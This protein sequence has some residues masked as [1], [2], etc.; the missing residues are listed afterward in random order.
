MLRTYNIPLTVSL[1]TL[2]FATSGCS[3]TTPGSTDTGA[4]GLSGEIKLNLGESTGDFEIEAGTSRRLRGSGQIDAQ[5]Q[6]ITS[7]TIRID[8]SSITFAPAADSDQTDQKA[9]SQQLVD[10]TIEIT[11]SLAAPDEQ[12][13]V[14]DEGQMYGPFV[15]TLGEDL[16]P[17]SVTPSSVDLTD[18][19]IDLLSTGSISLCVDILST[20]SGT[21]T[22]NN[23]IFNL[24]F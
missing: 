23:F 20:V 22:I 13:T 24:D 21:I 8:T 10:N 7:A 11:I 16:Q 19:T 12:D 18:E 2:L 3:T 17:L 9:A 1:I 14:C 6:T 5:G 4:Q 15:F